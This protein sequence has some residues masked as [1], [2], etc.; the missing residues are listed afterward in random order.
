VCQARSIREGGLMGGKHTLEFACNRARCEN[1]V[2]LYDMTC[3]QCRFA[4]VRYVTT[5][6]DVANMDTTIADPP[7][8]S[9]ARKAT[10]VF[11]G[12]L[13]YFPDAIAEVAKLS[14]MANDKHNPGEPMHWSRDKSKDHADSCVRHLMTPRAIDEFGLIHAVSA[15]WRALANLQI[16]IEEDRDADE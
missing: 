15:A 10:P 5:P 1:R 8:D 14:K 16:I 4:D 12:V 13:M 3:M 6:E 9:A 7:D 11:S 2:V